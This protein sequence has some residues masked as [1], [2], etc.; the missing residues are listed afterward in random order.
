MNPSW[1]IRGYGVNGSMTDSRPVDLGSNPSN[2]I[3][4]ENIYAVMI[5]HKSGKEINEISVKRVLEA[6]NAKVDEI[7]IKALINALGGVD[8]G[9]TVGSVPIPIEQPKVE[10][11]IEEKKEAVII[12]DERGD[13]AKGL[14]RLFS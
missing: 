3:K 4:M 1:P 9:K 5:L 13:A 11:K 12:E 8:I 10:Q 14:D 2:P 6:A 7:R